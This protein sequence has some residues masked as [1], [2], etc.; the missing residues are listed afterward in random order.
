MR[1][2]RSN[3]MGLAILGL[4]LALLAATTSDAEAREEAAAQKPQSALRWV[5]QTESPRSAP[6]VGP[7]YRACGGRDLA[8]V[9]V[10]AQIVRRR[11]QGLPPPSERQ[12]ETLLRASGVP[13][14]FPR[15]WALR[16]DHGDAVIVTK[17]GAWLAKRPPKGHRRCGIARGTDTEG[18][19]T[20]VVVAVDALADQTPLPTRARVSKWLALEASLH[21]TADDAKVVLLGPRGRPKRVLASLSGKTVRSRFMLDAPGRWKVQVV[22]YLSSGPQP[23]LESTVWVD[24]DPP[25][26]L[27]EE[28]PSAAGTAAPKPSALFRLLNEARRMEGLAPLKRDGKLDAVARDHAA[29]MMSARHA[30]HDVGRGLPTERVRRAGLVVHRVGEN[31]ASAPT[32]AR[33]HEALWD[34]PSHRENMLDASFRRTGVA[35]AIDRTGQLWAVQLFSE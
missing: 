19:P 17:L 2:A 1:P 18:V 4:V 13:Q 34:S 6:P 10:A 30:A 24:R 16:G 3:S 8:L 22:A 29:A 26:V 23:V 32:V 11:L 5:A 20:V 35:L 9:E 28:K 21:V 25:E 33:V 12:L 15:A 14:V 27:P 31:V 7:L